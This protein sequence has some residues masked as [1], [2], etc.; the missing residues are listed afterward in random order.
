MLWTF[1]RSGV[2]KEKHVSTLESKSEYNL[3]V[4]EEVPRKYVDIAMK[5]S[6]GIICRLYSVSELYII[7]LMTLVTAEKVGNKPEYT[8]RYS[9]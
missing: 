4:M 7:R 2:R 5:R 6:S 9:T 8:K 3:F 1:K